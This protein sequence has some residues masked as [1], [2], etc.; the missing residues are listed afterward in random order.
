M[1]PNGGGG[2]VIGSPTVKVSNRDVFGLRAV[3]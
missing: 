2:G 3:R 1:D